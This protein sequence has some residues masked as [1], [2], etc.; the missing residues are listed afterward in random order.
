M[1][2]QAILALILAMNT[3]S[4][5]A[6]SCDPKAESQELR[7]WSIPIKPCSITYVQK[8][9][10]IKTPAGEV[11]NSGERP[12]AYI[13]LSQPNRKEIAAVLEVYQACPPIL[14]PA[15]FEYGPIPKLEM[16]SPSIADQIWGPPTISDGV[17]TYKLSALDK[18]EYVLELKF[19]PD[20]LSKYK[21]TSKR[22]RGE[23]SW[24]LV[25]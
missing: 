12:P 5:T 4:A 22:L 9:K 13:F 25:Q 2:N 23:P 10:P 1:R 11:M 19:D 16:L 14:N 24:S 8:N 3:L 20:K 18:A 7:T 21:I 17:R 15:G 6:S